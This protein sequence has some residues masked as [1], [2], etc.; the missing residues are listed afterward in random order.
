[1]AARRGPKNVATA[2]KVAMAA[3]RQESR[4]VAAYLE[5][6]A[7][8]RPRRG[9]RRTPESIGARLEVIAGELDEAGLL[10]R[11][12]LVQERMD[13]EVELD[14]LTNT[15]DAE[16]FEALEGVGGTLEPDPAVGAAG[17][18]GCRFGGG[19]LA[20]SVPGRAGGVLERR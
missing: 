14:A 2:H 11:L 17:W 18:A 8:R 3:G 19:G 12:H 7:A 15:D 1:M 10:S 6:L 9:R 5:A 4:T 16:E 13:L 20:R